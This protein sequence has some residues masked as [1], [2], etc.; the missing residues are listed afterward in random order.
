MTPPLP[1]HTYSS[2]DH[3]VE[4]VI[5]SLNRSRSNRPAFLTMTIAGG[6]FAAYGL[7]SQRQKEPNSPH[8]IMSRSSADRIFT[9]SK[10]CPFGS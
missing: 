1:H 5:H 6:A 10:H 4:L 8:G 9:P 3:V 7:L 2:P